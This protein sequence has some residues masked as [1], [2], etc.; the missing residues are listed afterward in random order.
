MKFISLLPYNVNRRGGFVY[1]T[2]NFVRKRIFIYKL[3]IV[4]NY[5]LCYNQNYRIM[6]FFVVFLIK[7]E[8][9]PLLSV[10]MI[11]NTQQ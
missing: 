7:R 10:I 1:N 6:L 8:K 3:P 4:R 9:Q 5:S 2:L 11:D